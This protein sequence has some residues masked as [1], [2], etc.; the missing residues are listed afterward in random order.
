MPELMGTVFPRVVPA[1]PGG[2][3]EGPWRPPRVSPIGPGV[4]SGLRGGAA[5]IGSQGRARLRSKAMQSPVPPPGT[6]RRPGRGGGGCRPPATHCEPVTL[7]HFI[8]FLI[9]LFIFFFRLRGQ[10][11]HFIPFRALALP[12]LLVQRLLRFG[13]GGG[14]DTGGGVGE[15]AGDEV[16][17]KSNRRKNKTKKNR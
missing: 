7:H 2:K 16:G 8:K 6:R 5:R 15:G 12:V 14:R 3:Q 13:G 10:R 17:G 9:N 4:R 11:K 1:S